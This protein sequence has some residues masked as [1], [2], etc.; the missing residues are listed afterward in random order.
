MPIISIKRDWRPNISIVGII[1]TDTQDQVFATGYLTSQAAVINSINAGAFDWNGTDYVLIEY[2]TGCSFATLDSI[3]STLIPASGGGGGSGTVT[4]LT[5]GTNITLSPNPLTSSGTVSVTYPSGAGFKNVMDFM[6]AN[7]VTALLSNGGYNEDVSTYVNEAISGGGEI[8]FPSATYNFTSVIA[9]NPP[10]GTFLRGSNQGSTIFNFK[11]STANA[12]MINLTSTGNQFA[13]TN[14]VL[15]IQVIGSGSALNTQ[16]AFD[17]SSLRPIVTNVTVQGYFKGFFWHQ[18]VGATLTNVDCVGCYIAHF[19]APKVGSGEQ[20]FG[21]T[22]CTFINCHVLEGTNTSY[23]LDLCAENTWIGGDCENNSGICD[24][25]VIGNIFGSTGVCVTGMHFEVPNFTSGHFVFDP[26]GNQ[27]PQ[28]HII[29]NCDF[30]LALDS[31]APDGVY[32]VINSTNANQV[33]VTV[34]NCGIEIQGGIGGAGLHTPY[35]INNSGGI[36]DPTGVFSFTN[37]G[38]GNNLVVTSISADQTVAANTNTLVQWPDIT[39]NRTALTISGTGNTTF[40]NSDTI[41]HMYQVNVNT[42]TNGGSINFW[43]GDP[44]NDAVPKYGAGTT[45]T[46]G[47]T[48]IGISCVI[49]LPAGGQFCIYCE[50]A[51]TFLVGGAGGYNN[52]SA[53]IMVVNQ[54]T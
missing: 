42:P 14:G 26:T 39:Y 36:Q 30:C 50:A 17:I 24:F 5:A 51:F 9:N 29:T 46:V 15:D 40:T 37:S 31:G 45:G 54:I 33:Y 49:W 44:A 12:I 23:Y 53:G 21:M 43:I 28:N 48:Y 41:G 19:A 22:E 16:T 4:A 10:V 20:Q 27:Y 47:S 52:P 38:N 13:N 6:P 18:T 11:V 32:T 25:Y 2:S 34:Q 3:F 1:S 7:V 8:Y 35:Y